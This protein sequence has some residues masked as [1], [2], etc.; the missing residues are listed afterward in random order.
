[1][2]IHTTPED[3]ARAAEWIAEDRRHTRESDE[4]RAARLKTVSDLLQRQ[5]KAQA[6]YALRNATPR[7]ETK[8]DRWPFALAVAVF[9]V[10]TI[11]AIAGTAT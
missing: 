4:A 10:L 1:M 6:D 3:A 11:A 2:T 5:V 8:P 7:P 9:L